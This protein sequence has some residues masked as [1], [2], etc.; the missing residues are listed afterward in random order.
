MQF[1]GLFMTEPA[2]NKELRRPQV[3]A[4]RGASAYA[5]E[6]T[7][8]AFLKAIEMGADWFELDIQMTRDGAMAVFHDRDVSRFAVKHIPVYELTMGD[9]RTLD[10]GSWFSEEYADERVITLE[11]ALELAAGRIGVYI[12]LKSAVDETPRIPDMLEII[13]KSPTLT[14]WDWRYLM[15][16]GHRISADSVVQAQRAIQLVQQYRDRCNVVVQAFSPIMAAVF[17]YEAPDIPFE[18][19]GM[20]LPEPPHIWRDYVLYGEKIGI[21]GFNVFHGSLTEERFHY[22]RSRD[23]NCAVWVVDEAEDI[24]HFARLGVQGIISNKPDLCMA[25]LKA[26]S[27]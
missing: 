14:R 8:A 6:N 25:E 20:D 22:F 16:A 4:H 19:L 11:E 23:K 27:E 18:F 12:E 2:D 26:L 10:V 15:D 1:Q 13:Y 17:R 24:R 3:I 5:P 9:M 21:N 7:R